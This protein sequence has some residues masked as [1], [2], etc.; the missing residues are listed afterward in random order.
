MVMKNDI[1]RAIVESTVR[2]N[3]KNYDTDPKRTIR[4]MIDAGTRLTHS[5]VQA[6][7]LTTVGT[8]FSNSRSLYYR[9]IDKLFQNVNRETLMHFGVNLGFGAW[10][11]GSHRISLYEKLNNTEIPWIIEIN[12]REDHYEKYTPESIDRIIAF[13]NKRGISS[14]SVFFHALPE[15]ILQNFCKAILRHPD[16]DFLISLPDVQLTESFVKELSA[17][18]NLLVLIPM[19]GTEQAGMEQLFVRNGIFYGLLK[20]ISRETLTDPG[21]DISPLLDTLAGKMKDAETPIC[22]L[23]GTPDT[24]ETDMLRSFNK[25]IKRR[26]RPDMPYLLASYFCDIQ[27][28]NRIISSE[29]VDILFENNL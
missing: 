16:S 24:P 3:F 20:P 6:E 10:S 18:S 28:I 15:N 25:I 5:R 9:S 23:K 12:I 7:L 17:L 26:M 29:S 1:N 2:L 21:F 13:Y 14:F 11:R 19:D 4:R 27:K 8:L 22:F